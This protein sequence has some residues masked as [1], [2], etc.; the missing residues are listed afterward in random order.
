MLV[1]VVVNVVAADVDLIVV[2]NNGAA[3]V[4]AVTAFADVSTF[5][6]V[7]NVVNVVASITF[8]MVAILFR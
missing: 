2:I 4:F 6:G 8:L 7:S 1:D 5:V 3:I